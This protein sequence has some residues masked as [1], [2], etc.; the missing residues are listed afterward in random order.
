MGSQPTRIQLRKILQ[1]NFVGNSCRKILWEVL[2]E[3]L[4]KFCRKPCRNLVG[5]CVGNVAGG[6]SVGEPPLPLLQGSSQGSSKDMGP[7]AMMPVPVTPTS[8]TAK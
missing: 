7:V 4:R 3:V 5:N 6:M 2:L 8:D 1:E